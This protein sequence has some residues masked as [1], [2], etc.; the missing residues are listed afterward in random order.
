GAVRGGKIRR[1]GIRSATGFA[2]LCHDTVGFLRASAVVHENL[3]AG[4]GERQRAGAA[5]AA[6]SA[7]NQGGFAGQSSHNHRPCCCCGGSRDRFRS[8]DASALVRRQEHRDMPNEEFGILV[9]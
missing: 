9:L 8:S 5:Y 4:G 6:R 1:Y 2:Y 7:G 3:A